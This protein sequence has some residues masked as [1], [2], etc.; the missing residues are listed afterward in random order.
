MTGVQLTIAWAMRRG[1][2]IVPVLGT[3][4]VAQLEEALGAMAIRLTAEEVASLEAAVPPEKVQGTRYDK[5]AMTH[6]DS[7]R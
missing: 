7:E 2:E 6:L 5:Q 4:K 3:R 1:E